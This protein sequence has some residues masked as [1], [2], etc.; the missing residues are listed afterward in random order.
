MVEVEMEFMQSVDVVLVMEV[1]MVEM[2]GGR[3]EEIR[4]E[5]EVMEATGETAV[6]M[7]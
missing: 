1:E 6:V 5:E 3:A 2:V 7:L 4:V